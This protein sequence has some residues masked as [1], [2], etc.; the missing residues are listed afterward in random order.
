MCNKSYNFTF[1]EEKG[2]S[3]FS[4][5]NK[6]QAI[7]ESPR[8]V[9]P[10]PKAINDLITNKKRNVVTVGLPSVQAQN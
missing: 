5:Q 1:M 10:Q 2:H 9:D 6:M 4:M 3:D 7:R 8:V